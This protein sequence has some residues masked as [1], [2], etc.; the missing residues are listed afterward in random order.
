MK[1]TLLTIL[2]FFILFSTA[3]FAQETLPVTNTTDAIP[4]NL[5]GWLIFIGLKTPLLG[6]FQRILKA[7]PQNAVVKFLL[8][9]VDL[10]AANTSHVANK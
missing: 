6:V 10:L 7:L 1:K 5:I 3:L 2:T 4:T 9:I 8:S